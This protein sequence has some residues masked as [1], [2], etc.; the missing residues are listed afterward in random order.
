MTL[1]EAKAYLR[2]TST[3][4]DDLIQSLITAADS[5]IKQQTGK[6]KKVVSGVE[7][8]IEDD[9]LYNIATKLMIAHW[10]ENRQPETAGTIVARFSNSIDALI[11][12]ISL[13]GDYT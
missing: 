3:A 7:T 9:K 6:T 2:I 11:N 12:H 1:T 10:Y 4:D 8:D 5:Y 13:C